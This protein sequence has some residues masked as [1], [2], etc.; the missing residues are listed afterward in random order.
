MSEFNRRREE[1]AF[2][3]RLMEKLQ[4]VGRLNIEEVKAICTKELQLAEEE[5][6]LP[7]LFDCFEVEVERTGDN[8]FCATVRQ[9]GNHE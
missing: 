5:G 3:A 2:R 6:R 9:R 1:A 4:D 7:G 8:S